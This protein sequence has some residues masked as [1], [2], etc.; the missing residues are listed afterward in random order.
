M[1][2]TVGTGEAM[3]RSLQTKGWVGCQCQGTPPLSVAAEEAD[4]TTLMAERLHLDFG[5]LWTWWNVVFCYFAWMFWFIM[6]GFWNYCGLG[7]ILICGL[8][9]YVRSWN[10]LKETWSILYNIELWVGVSNWWVWGGHNWVGYIKL[11][12]PLKPI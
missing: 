7:D 12:Y 2:Q 10:T 3:L 8:L 6:L 11:I 4:L 5:L 9:M 1:K